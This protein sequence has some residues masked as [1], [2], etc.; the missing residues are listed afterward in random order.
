[1]SFHTLL[2]VGTSANYQKVSKGDVVELITG[3][4]VTFMEMKR[5]KWNGLMNG[6]GIIVPVYRKRTR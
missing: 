3:E 6:K 2:P 1:M 4:K 5:S